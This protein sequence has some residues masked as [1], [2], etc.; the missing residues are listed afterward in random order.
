M[1]KCKKKVELGTLIMKMLEDEELYW[2]K[3]SHEK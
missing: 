3:R 1:N 2:H